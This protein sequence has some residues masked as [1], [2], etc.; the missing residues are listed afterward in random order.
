MNENYVNIAGF[1]GTD[2]EART[3]GE[4]ATVAT[5]RVA[6]TP[7]RWSSKEREWIDGETNWYTVNAWR[8]LGRNCCDSL[9]K[10]DPITLYG[11][12]SV[13]VWRD[14]A[15][16]ERSTLV[17]DAACIGHDLNRGR[18]TFERVMPEEVDT[19]SLAA[20]NASLGVGGP[21]VS[22]DGTT[23]DDLVDRVEADG[24]IAQAS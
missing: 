3:V 20:S 18:S 7:R 14:D 19:N 15:G 9:R 23:I 5:F 4:G 2:V 21:Q 11:K 13:Q 24:V 16:N 17:V 8:M 6:S 1:V 22:S 12:L 10:G